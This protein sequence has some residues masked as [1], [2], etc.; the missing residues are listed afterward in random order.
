[1]CVL[2]CEH[3]IVCAPWIKIFNISAEILAKYRISVTTEAKSVMENRLREKSLKNRK[4][5]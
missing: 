3:D 2:L 4:F 1:M 5:R